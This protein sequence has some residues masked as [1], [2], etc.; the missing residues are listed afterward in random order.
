MFFTPHYQLE[1]SKGINN[2]ESRVGISWRNDYILTIYFALPCL[3]SSLASMD[4]SFPNKQES[5]LPSPLAKT[6]A[7]FLCCPDLHLKV[8]TK[9]SKHAPFL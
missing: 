9:N 8:I 6:A 3:S 1:F 7:S 2:L 4:S 5:S